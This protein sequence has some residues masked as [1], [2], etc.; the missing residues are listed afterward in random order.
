MGETGVAE[1]RRRIPTSQLEALMRAEAAL[2][3]RSPAI[4]VERL[5]CEPSNWDRQHRLLNAMLDDWQTR[6]RDVL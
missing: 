2:A 3:R 4:V 1:Q 5:G 6:D